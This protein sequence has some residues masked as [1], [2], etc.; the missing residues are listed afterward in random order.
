MTGL[1]TAYRDGYERTVNKV[2]FAFDPPGV[3]QRLESPANR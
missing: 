2:W 3:V 1:T